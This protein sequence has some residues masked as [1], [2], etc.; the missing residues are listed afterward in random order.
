MSKRPGGFTLI[1]AVMGSLI[2]AVGALV[3]C[4]LAQRC[5]WNYGRGMEYEK[6]YRLLDECPD[7]A[8]SGDFGELVRQREVVG[9]FGQRGEGYKYAVEVKEEE[10]AGLY[11]VSAVVSWQGA[12]Q[13]YKVTGTTLVY[14]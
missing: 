13:E 4:G 10:T 12:G 1:E 8:V 7:R 5:A 3:V 9:D 11:E 2:L 6:A 14:R